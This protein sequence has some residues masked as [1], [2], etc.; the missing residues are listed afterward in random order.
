ME[1]ENR[2]KLE[3]FSSINDMYV[4]NAFKTFLL[5]IVN[6]VYYLNKTTN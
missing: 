3:Q 5:G 1:K 4:W 2:G 6:Q